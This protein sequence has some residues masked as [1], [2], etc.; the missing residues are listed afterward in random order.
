MTSLLSSIHHLGIRR[1]WQYWR[2]CRTARK[3]R[4]LLLA[5]AEGL[6]HEADDLYADDDWLAADR[7]MSFAGELRREAH[8]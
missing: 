7:L 8:A 4:V 6:E 3:D 2:M 5:W 1:G